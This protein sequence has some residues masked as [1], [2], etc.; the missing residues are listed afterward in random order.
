MTSKLHIKNGKRSALRELLLKTDRRRLHHLYLSSCY[1]TPASA[2]TLIKELAKAGEIKLTDVAVYIDR[3]TA[4]FHGKEKL[5]QF[6]R[7]T[8]CKVELFAVNSSNLFHSKA[9]ALISYDETDNIFCGSLVLGSANLTGNGLND[10]SRGNVEC[11]LD[12]QDIEDLDEFIS[13]LKSLD[14]ANL[15][16]IESFESSDSFAFKYAL[17]QCGEFVHKWTDNLAQY[18]AI[19]Y[20]LNEYGRSRIADPIFGDMGFN[21]ET[22]T[23]SKRYFQFDYEPVHLEDAE[24]LTRTNG[25]ETYLGYWVPRSALSSL[26]KK[27]GL[28][29]F[30]ERLFSSLEEQHSNIKDKIEND[31]KY[32]LE[33][34]IIEKDDSGPMVKFDNKIQN[35]KDNEC[36]IMR[37]FSKY[38]VFKLP[39]DIQEKVKIED[40]FDDM[41][42]LC[43][44][45]QRKN[46]A[47]R[48]FLQAIEAVNL[49]MLNE[50]GYEE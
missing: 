3:K 42:E 12:T 17:L 45:S 18:F 36:K 15:D 27:D 5:E 43:E 50:I 28:E 21:V 35:L 16:E 23:I 49:E 32:L 25:I 8:N 29:E 38:E 40:L 9:Y 33:A 34:G 48:G 1:F 4:N 11:L 7:S 22:A 39:Y 26:F 30:K 2:T 6:C 41:V 20:R 47:K 13:Q 24:N 44:S 19:K 46:V 31:T 10:D 37:I 14:I